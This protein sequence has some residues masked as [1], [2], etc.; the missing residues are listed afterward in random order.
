MASGIGQIGQW[1]ALACLAVCLY[2]YVGYPLVLA[3]AAAVLGRKHKTADI[4]PSVS[5]LIPAYNEIEVIRSKIDNSLALDYP[6]DKLQI[7]VV[8]DGSDDGTDDAVR[9]YADR[10]VELQRIQP[11]GGKANAVNQA[12]TCARGDI[13]LLCDANTMFAPDAISRLVRHFADPDVGAVTGDVRLSSTDVTYGQGEGLFFRLERFI[14]ATESNMWTSIGVDGGMY[15]I[16]RD[17][18]V[19]NRPDTLIDDFVIGMNVARAGKRVIYDPQAVA[20]EDAVVSPAQEFRRRTRTIAGGFQTLFEGRG[21][22]RWHQVGLW[23]GYLSHKVLRWLGPVFLALLISGSTAAV[24]AGRGHGARW[25][26]FV[27]LLALQG[28]FYLL[29]VTGYL[30][31]RRRL[32]SLLCIPYYFC[33]GNAA[34]A[35]GLVKW[36]RGSQAVTW[37]KADRHLPAGDAP[38]ENGGRSPISLDTHV[39]DSDGS[40]GGRNRGASPIFPEAE[41]SN[42][43]VSRLRAAA[44]SRRAE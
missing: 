29:A 34:A 22:P 27:V 12:V 36:F 7:R 1:V 4:Q 39:S 21:R 26:F 31:R 24:A 32:P 40:G 25:T 42:E 38:T 13:L 9:H 37:R 6:A 8:S 23:A 16:R 3:L 18:Y 17:L 41:C 35:V 5:L 43:K 11:R 28:V 10:G 20:T 2:T 19:P 30:F 33:L 44:P 15:A 14:Q